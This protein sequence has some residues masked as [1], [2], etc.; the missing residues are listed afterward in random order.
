MHPR[1]RRSLGILPPQCY[2]L[3]AAPLTIRTSSNTSGT[4]I[5]VH[6]GLDCRIPYAYEDHKKYTISLTFFTGLWDCAWLAQCKKPGI[7]WDFDFHA[8]R[9]P[10]NVSRQLPLYFMLAQTGVCKPDSE[11]SETWQPEPMQLKDKVKF[12]RHLFGKWRPENS[13]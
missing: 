5:G 4:R 6:N 8:S 1:S 9:T 7:S 10:G 13:E 12:I 11:R 3:H 2:E